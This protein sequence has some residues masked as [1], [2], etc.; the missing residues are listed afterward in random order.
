M[1]DEPAATPYFPAAL[2]W[3][4]LAFILDIILVGLASWTFF[5]LVV[6]PRAYPGFDA[7]YAAYVESLET[8]DHLPPMPADVL[9][10]LQMFNLTMAFAVLL[11]FT[12]SEYFW[13]GRTLG[14]RS[15]RIRAARVGAPEEAPSLMEAFIRSLCKAVCMQI[16]LLLIADFISVFFGK[17][18]LALHD[19]MARTV[20]V[21]EA[22][23]KAVSAEPLS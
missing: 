12:L 11:Y 1:N 16:G 2:L 14:K 5:S 9:E 15:V 6:A 21:D 18:R 13:R 23:P 20:V 7:R 10:P 19:R 3:R 17:K 4:A 8:L 22:R